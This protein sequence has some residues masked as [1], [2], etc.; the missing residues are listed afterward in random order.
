MVGLILAS[1]ISA[2][3]NKS[4][5]EVVN[6]PALTSKTPT[7]TS[8]IIPTPT[9]DY[10]R[11]Q[12]RAALQTRLEYLNIQIVHLQQIVDFNNEANKHMYATLQAD[13]N[14]PDVNASPLM[15]DYNQQLIQDHVYQDR[16]SQ[17]KEERSEIQAVLGV[18]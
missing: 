9:I 2:N 4:E 17:F 16:L 14:N 11:I 5:A 13:L 12:Q 18:N 1:T 8:T 10:Q 6:V 3:S 7:P 15:A